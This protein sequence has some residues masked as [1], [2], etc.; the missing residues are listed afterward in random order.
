ME[1][2]KMSKY[3]RKKALQAQQAAAEAKAEKV[4]ALAAALIPP[5][6]KHD[7]ELR[8]REI[9]KPTQILVNVLKDVSKSL[10]NSPKD[11]AFFGEAIGGIKLMN[12]TMRRLKD[13][14]ELLKQ[15]KSHVQGTARSDFD[16]IVGLL[17]GAVHQVEKI[18]AKLV[19][20]KHRE[21]SNG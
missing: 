11:R 15:H 2:E 10:A 19:A 1:F 14:R 12:Q 9:E 6:S 4:A 13:F 8:Q 16:A 7:I 18:N 17:Q 20:I 21:E 5:K 3:A